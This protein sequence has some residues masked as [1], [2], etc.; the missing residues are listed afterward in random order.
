MGEKSIQRDSKNTAVISAS[1]KWLYRAEP[2][3]H[4]VQTAVCSTPF[5]IKKQ[6]EGLLNSAVFRPFLTDKN[7]LSYFFSFV[8]R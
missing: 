5:F 2:Y 7:S 6:D 1:Y 4:F 3:P 8:M